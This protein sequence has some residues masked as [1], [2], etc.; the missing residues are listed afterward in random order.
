MLEDV[1]LPG[2]LWK[3]FYCFSEALLPKFVFVN[4][5]QNSFTYKQS[6][7]LIIKSGGKCNFKNVSFIFEGKEIYISLGFRQPSPPQPLETTD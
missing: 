4:K 5:S 7:S 2:L 6:F 1:F 3:F